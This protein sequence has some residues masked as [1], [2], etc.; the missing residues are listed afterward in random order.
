MYTDTIVEFF[1]ERKKGKKTIIKYVAIGVLLTLFP[2]MVS[3]LMSICTPELTPLA[4][5]KC[6]AALRILLCS[7]R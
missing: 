3:V 1:V 7:V 5:V 6:T 4:T 2:I